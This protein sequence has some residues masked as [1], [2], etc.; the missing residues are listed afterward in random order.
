MGE[1]QFDN[2]QA[3]LPPGDHQGSLGASDKAWYTLYYQWAFCTTPPLLKDHDADVK[4]IL[5]SLTKKEEIQYEY[6]DEDR[7]QCPEIPQGASIK[8]I[9]ASVLPDWLTSRKIEDKEEDGDGTV[10]LDADA[11]QGLL[12]KAC[13]DLYDENDRLRDEISQLRSQMDE[14]R[15][16]VTDLAGEDS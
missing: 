7:A 4:S 11:M 13:K 8:K 14:L 15:A 3:V 9:D 5:H 16:M 6:T 2:V 12:V 10:Y 1:H